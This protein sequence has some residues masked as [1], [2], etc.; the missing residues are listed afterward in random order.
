VT[1]VSD[2]HDSYS[3]KNRVPSTCGAFIRGGQGSIAGLIILGLVLASARTARSFTTAMTGLSPVKAVCRNDITGQSVPLQL[4]GM[5]S[6]D[7]E[8]AGLV[9]GPEERLSTFA[10]GTIQ[11]SAAEVGGSVTSLLPLQ[12]DCRNLTTGQAILRVPLSGNSSW[13]CTQH[14]LT[15]R[16]GDR[17]KM[18][19]RGTTM[20]RPAKITCKAPHIDR[21][22]QR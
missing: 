2:S 7:C 6:W 1:D 13:S 10:T 15:V 16:V 9:F 5:T 17:V 4:A 18:R 8:A 14:G 11:E 20:Q 3:S 12:V 22:P 19:D 21:V